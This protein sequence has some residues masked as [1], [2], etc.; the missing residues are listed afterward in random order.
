VTSNSANGGVDYSTYLRFSTKTSSTVQYIRS[1]RNNKA[2]LFHKQTIT[3][4]QPCPIST[5]NPKPSETENQTCAKKHNTTTAYAT[6]TAGGLSTSASGR[7]THAT[8]EAIPRRSNALLPTTRE[9]RFRV[10][11][12]T[13]ACGPSLRSGEQWMQLRVIEGTRGI[14]GAA[15]RRNRTLALCQAG[16][17]PSIA[18]GTQWHWVLPWLRG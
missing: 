12:M 3:Q 14:Q 10:C 7:T 18:V 5:T 8:N 13:V 15:E 6:T 1:N 16:W 2:S 4:V 11:A 17:R 9:N